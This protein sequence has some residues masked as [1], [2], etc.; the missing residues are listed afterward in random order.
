[1][2]LI[3]R[4]KNIMMTPKTE[5]PVID[6]EP[7]DA[8]SLF[9][10]YVAILAAIPAICG[11]IGS[12]IV[13]Y[14]IPGTG[15]V[16]IGVGQGLA[17][18]IVSYLLTLAGVY[19]MALVIDAL[20]ATFGGR[21]HSESALKSASYSYTPIALAGFFLLLPPLGLLIPLITVAGLAYALYLLWTGLPVLMRAPA[22]KALVYA[23]AAVVCAAVIWLILSWILSGLFAFP[24]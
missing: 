2:T 23:L 15:T 5:W 7:G 12:S 22:D 10:N 9:K 18:M 19:V 4:V 14:S 17:L 13:G 8:A 20:A 21:K 3:D 24:G 6:R 1:M 16:R 11:F